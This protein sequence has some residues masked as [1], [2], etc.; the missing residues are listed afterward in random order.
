MKCF[1]VCSYVQRLT[2]FFELEQ[3]PTPETTGKCHI[4][5]VT[6]VHPEYFMYRLWT[7]NSIHPTLYLSFR[8]P[9]VFNQTF[10]QA[11]ANSSHG[12]MFVC[13]FIFGR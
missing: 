9:S 13:L 2:P 3:V 5:T 11:E 7:L 8:A 4:L 12:L 1:T 10:D 6:F